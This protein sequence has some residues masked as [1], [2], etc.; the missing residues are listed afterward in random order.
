MIRKIGE[1]IK[2]SVKRKKAIKNKKVWKRSKW[3]IEIM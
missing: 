3:K 2:R 1:E